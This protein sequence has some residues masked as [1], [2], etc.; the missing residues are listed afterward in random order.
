MPKFEQVDLSILNLECPLVQEESPIEKV[1]PVLGASEN[2]AK[3]LAA[4]GIDVA[5]LANNHIFDHG[6]QGLRNTISACHRAGLKVVGAGEHLAEARR[7][8]CQDVHGVRVGIVAVAEHEFSIALRDRPGANPLDVIEFVRQLRAHKSQLDYVV[9]LL[10]GGNEYYPYPSP[11]LQQVCRFMIEEGAHAVLCQHSH[12][13]GSYEVYRGGHIVYGQGNLFFD[14]FPQK[15]GEWNR[16]FLVQL[17]VTPGRTAE[18]ELIPYIQSD[19]QPGA[20][21]MAV[22]EGETFLRELQTRSARVTHEEFIERKWREFCRAKRY[23]YFSIMRGHSRPV[24]FLNRMT[25]F[26]DRL[27]SRHSLMTLQNVVRC[28]A[29]RQVL[30]TL[31]SER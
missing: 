12:C 1:G 3:G 15:Q 26:T 7:V 20:R 10:H 4:L 17:S 29:H 24:R 23:L 30:Q 19:Q 25:H 21:R 22:V 9:V 8:L 14:R 6:E 5:G 18:M 11:A 28:E 27:Y 16:G 2:C 31:L 13:A